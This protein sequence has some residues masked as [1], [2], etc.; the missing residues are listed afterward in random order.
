MTNTKN[1]Y[2]YSIMNPTECTVG[3]ATYHEYYECIDYE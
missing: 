2:K 1:S 3:G